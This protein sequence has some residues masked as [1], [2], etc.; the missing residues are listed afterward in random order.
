MHSLPQAAGN[1][2][3]A[4]TDAEY[5]FEKMVRGVGELLATVDKGVPVAM[6]NRKI[7]MKTKARATDMNSAERGRCLLMISS[8]RT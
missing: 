2:A 4:E 1:S 3:V 6:L 7:V 8:A 5:V